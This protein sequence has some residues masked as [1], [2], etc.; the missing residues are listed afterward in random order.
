MSWWMS[1]WMWSF[2]MRNVIFLADFNAEIMNCFLHYFNL[3]QFTKCQSTGDSTAFIPECQYGPALSMIVNILQKFQTRIFY[4]VYPWNNKYYHQNFIRN[5]NWRTILNLR[6]SL[7]RLRTLIKN[8]IRVAQ[9]N[10]FDR[11]Q[12]ELPQNTSQ[13][14]S[15]VHSKSEFNS[16]S[17]VRI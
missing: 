3:V 14:R 17:K 4:M 8:Q 1:R 11:A 2:L 7:R 16:D 9:S 5:T 12:T 6:T 15:F 13:F 10:F